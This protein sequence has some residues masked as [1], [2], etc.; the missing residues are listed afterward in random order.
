MTSPMIW[1]PATPPSDGVPTLEAFAERWLTDQAPAWKRSHVRTVRSSLAFWVLP[2]LGTWRLDAI[3]RADLLALRAWMHAH[4]RHPSPA[5]INKVMGILVALVRE[6]ALRHGLPDPAIG[7]RA[8]TVPEPAIHPFSLVEVERLLDV[9]KAP[10]NDYFAVR[11]FTG[12][13]TGEVDGLRWED[14]DMATRRLTIRRAW[15]DGAWETPKSRAGYRDV[16]LV[17]RAYDALVR[18]Q[19]RTGQRG[20]L[21]FATARDTPLSR[22]NVTRR[23]WYPALDA[24]G[25]MRRRAYQTRHTYATLML[26]A[27]EN[28]EFIRQQMG[29]RD[30]RVLFSRYARYVPNL[31]RRDGSALDEL[32]TGSAAAQPGVVG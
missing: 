17:A 10:W 21:V 14:V 16:V 4:P 11:F 3:G 25:L 7:M 28:V 24:L 1:T 5:R 20:P 31:T 30:A 15:V 9:L 8:L 32:L 19:A 18:Q 23:V 22:R 27:G 13:R 2:S 26:A 6:G 12:L 29:H